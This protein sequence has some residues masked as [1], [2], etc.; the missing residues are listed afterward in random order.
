[1]DL[2]RGLRLRGHLRACDACRRFR[3]VS[4]V[5]RVRRHKIRRDCERAIAWWEAKGEEEIMDV[6]GCAFEVYPRNLQGPAEYCIEPTEPNSVYCY[7]HN[8]DRCEPDWDDV[9][10]ESLYDCYG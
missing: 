3:P 7:Q 6:E 4:G 8:P 10:K 5:Q 2:L 1:M 9:R